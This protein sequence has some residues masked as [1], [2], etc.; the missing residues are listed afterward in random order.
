MQR[1]FKLEKVQETRNSVHVSASAP[2]SP[3]QGTPVSS[4]SFHEK[5]TDR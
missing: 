1:E 5:K 2:S 3:A 4:P